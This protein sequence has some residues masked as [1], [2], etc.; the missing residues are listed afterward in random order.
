MSIIKNSNIYYSITMVTAVDLNSQ[1]FW[2]MPF[3]SLCEQQQLVEF[4]VIQIEPTSVVNNK[5]WIM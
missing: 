5:V 1:V 2:R 4:F 3:V